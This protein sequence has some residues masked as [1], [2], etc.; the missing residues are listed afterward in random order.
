MSLPINHPLIRAIEANDLA[1]VQAEMG[2]VSVPE[3]SGALL[4]SCIN[5]KSAITMALLSLGV[6]SFSQEALKESLE[7]A[8]INGDY[9]IVNALMQ[10]H[11]VEDVNVAFMTAVTW[12]EA[13]LIAAMAPQVDWDD[14]I[15]LLK[16]QSSPDLSD[17]ERLERLDQLAP[18][19]PED[20]RQK[21]IR[22]FDETVFPLI[23]AAAEAF[24]RSERAGS[25]DE[26][27]SSVSLRPRVRP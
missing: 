11:A 6:G 12:G 23:H 5:A 2:D 18:F 20:H 13:A 3:R 21:L 8:T 4:H 26:K 17:V 24:R 27:P 9:Q 7:T 15:P 22:Q 1:T 10:S 19:M 25:L 14:F 16:D